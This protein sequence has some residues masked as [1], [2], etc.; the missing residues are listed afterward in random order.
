MDAGL[1]K[2]HEVQHEW[3]IEELLDAHEWLDLKREAQEARDRETP[4]R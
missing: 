2:L 4:H 3:D 1:G